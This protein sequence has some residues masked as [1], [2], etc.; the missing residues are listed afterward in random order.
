MRA[1]GQPGNELGVTEAEVVDAVRVRVPG[2]PDFLITVAADD[3]LAAG[4]RGDVE[5]HREVAEDAHAF[6]GQA[7][8]VVLNDVTAFI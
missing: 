6:A 7:H 2:H 1:D 8:D 4:G 3:E 5:Q